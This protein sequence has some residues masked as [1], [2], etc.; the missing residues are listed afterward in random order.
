LRSRYDV[1]LDDNRLLTVDVSGAPDGVPVF[2]LHGTPGS[3]RGPKPRTSVLYRLGVQ[4]ICYDR[5]GYGGSTRRVGRLVAD[6]AVDISAIADRL[7]I[8][9]FSI[10][11]RSGGGPHALAS[12]AL[13]ADRVD[14]AAVLVGLA[15]AN[16]EGLDWFEGMSDG[17]VEEYSTAD[18]S[19]ADLTA[20]LK[21][22][23]SRTAANPESLIEA[24]RPQMSGPDL[25]FVQST[26][27]RRL[28]SASYE[29]A[30][31]AGPF[32]W[33][34]DVLAFRADWGFRLADITNPVLLWHGADDTFS[35]AQ[36][37]RWLADQ[38]PGAVVAVQDNAAHFAAVEVLPTILGWLTA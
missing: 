8:G 20:G 24:L 3:R 35:P 29:E 15:P 18:Q 13:L 38:I 27:F 1:V 23:A 12:I 22:Q 26:L 31:R 37:S 4:L 5:P 28:L 14:R 10:V 7:G 16:A 25:K 6:A 11:G 21:A 33:I 32:G 17:N 36:H 34:D 9:R 30:L 19:V 2:L